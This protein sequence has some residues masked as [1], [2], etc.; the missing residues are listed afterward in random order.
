M[1]VVIAG[2]DVIEDVVK[3]ILILSAQDVVFK[4]P[5]TPC[6]HYTLIAPFI[7]MQSTNTYCSA[8]N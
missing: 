3:V 5:P 6:M 1:H 4:A 8:R 7:Y 2:G